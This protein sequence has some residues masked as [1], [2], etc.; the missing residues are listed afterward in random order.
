MTEIHKETVIDVHHWSDTLFTIKTTRDRSLRFRNGEF[1]M[2]GIEVEGKP[3]MRAYSMA[4]ANY[5]DHL[6]FYSIKVQQGALTSRLQHI[7][8]G[9]EILVSKKPTGTLLWDRLRPGKH[10]YL[11][12]TGTGLAPFLSIIKDPEVYENFEKVILVHGCRYI[13]ELT[14]QQLIT[15]ELKHNEY[16]GDSVKEKLIYYP[17]VTREPYINYGRITKLLQTGKLIEDIGTPAL[18]REDDRFMLC[19]SPSMLTSLTEILDDLGFTETRKND[20]GEYVIER[21]FVEK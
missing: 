3:L 13:N 20:L 1:A 2:M 21:A 7:I 19:G 18:N 10:L 11:L 9:D 16:F 12:S 8:A 15:H 4:S 5:E 14:Y 6:E 17:A